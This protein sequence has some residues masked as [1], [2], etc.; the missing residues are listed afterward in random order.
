[1]GPGGSLGS[2]EL[3]FFSLNDR[4]MGVVWLKVARENG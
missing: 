4:K 2:K 3:P 1:M